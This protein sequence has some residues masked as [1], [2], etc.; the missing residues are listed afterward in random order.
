MSS[1]DELK[2]LLFKAKAYVVEQRKLHPRAG[3]STERPLQRQVPAAAPADPTPAAAAPAPRNSNPNPEAPWAGN[4]GDFEAQICGCK[5][6]PL[7]SSRK[8]FVFGTGN[9]SA[10]LVFV[11]AA[12]SAE[13][14]QSGQPFAG[15]TG[16]LLAKIVTAMGFKREDVYVLNA[17]KCRPPQG[18]P[19]SAAEQ[20]ACRPF[21]ERQLELLSPKAVCS[22]GPEATAALL[23]PGL[24]FKES[25]G[26]FFEQKSWV[27]MPSHHPAELLRNEGLKRQAWE[28]M[29]ALLKK[30]S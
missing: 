28:D 30:I 25:R 17:V 21:F 26:K 4:L 20:E 18:Q 13:D 27:V 7:G 22:L 10:K 8:R 14:E 1:R 9:P 19:A 3:L 5:R 12:P 29:K 24:D 11:G 16:K 15:E 23:G 6:C 2:A